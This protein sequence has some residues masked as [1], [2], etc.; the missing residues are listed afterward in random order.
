MEYDRLGLHYKLKRKSL[1]M[2]KNFMKGIIK[3]VLV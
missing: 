1:K 2:D 3:V